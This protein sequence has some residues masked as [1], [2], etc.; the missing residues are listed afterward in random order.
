MVTTMTFVLIDTAF[1]ALILWAVIS[2]FL[3][4]RI[5][6]A[7]S[8]GLV[9]LFCLFAIFSYPRIPLSSHLLSFTLVFSGAILLYYFNVMGGGDVKFEIDDEAALRRGEPAHFA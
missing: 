7:V 8:I 4:L 5:A 6:N 9:L 3:K 1:L 2:D